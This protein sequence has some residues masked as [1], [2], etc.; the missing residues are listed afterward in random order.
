M[1]LADH[2]IAY[3]SN[4]AIPKI[5]FWQ[6]ERINSPEFDPV[7]HDPRF[8]AVESRLREYAG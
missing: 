6:L 2:A 8:S 1:K 4:G 3:D 7:R 5:C